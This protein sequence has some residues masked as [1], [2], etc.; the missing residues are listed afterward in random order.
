MVGG[1]CCLCADPVLSR[2][3]LLPGFFCSFQSIVE[4]FGWSYAIVSLAFTFRGFESGIMAPIVG[5]LVDRFGPRKLLLS[6][7]IISGLGFWFF[8]LVQSLWSFYSAFLF[9]A[10]GLP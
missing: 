2:R 4:E 7:V 9:L 5:I 6:G 10:L 1:R 8:S 3:D